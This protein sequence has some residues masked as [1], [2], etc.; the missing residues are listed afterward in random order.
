MTFSAIFPGNL[1]MTLASRLSTG[2]NLGLMKTKEQ[3]FN[4]AMGNIALT[5]VCAFVF[6]CLFVCLCVCVCVCVCV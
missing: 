4:T 1:E 5:Q 6:V 2:A 3:K